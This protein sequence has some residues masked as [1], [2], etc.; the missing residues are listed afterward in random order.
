DHSLGLWLRDGCW[1]RLLLLQL[2]CTRSLLGPELVGLTFAQGSLLTRLFLAPRL[3]L[4]IDG[5]RR[6]FRR[7]NLPWSR[8][9]LHENALLAHLHLN[10]ARLAAAIGLLDFG[11]LTTRQGD[12]RLRL[13]RTM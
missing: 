12:S 9:T 3:L 11:R 13:L 6:R 10:G 8:I 2:G 4:L 1:R 5:W 7:S